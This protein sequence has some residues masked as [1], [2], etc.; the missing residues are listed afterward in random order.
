MG[1]TWQE[2]GEE[3]V[4]VEGGKYY[5]QRIKNPDIAMKMWFRSHCKVTKKN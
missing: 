2:M 5:P 1:G 3:K 4:E